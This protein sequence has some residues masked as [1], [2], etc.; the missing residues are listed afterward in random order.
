MDEELL[1]IV[2]E[3][4]RYDYPIVPKREYLTTQKIPLIRQVYAR[5]AKELY[6]QS[7]KEV[8]IIGYLKPIGKKIT[9]NERKIL[10][11]LG[12]D[13]ESISKYALFAETSQI[14]SDVFV[15]AEPYKVENYFL[16]FECDLKRL[17]ENQFYLL[18]YKPTYLKAEGLEL[19]KPS[20]TYSG[21]IKELS[22]YS[23]F[24]PLS[25]KHIFRSL[26]FPYIGCSFCRNI[27]DGFGVAQ[28]SEDKVEALDILKEFHKSLSSEKLGVPFSDFGIVNLVGESDIKK[29]SDYR[30]RLKGRARSISW[31]NPCSE[32]ESGLIKLSEL[33]YHSSE[34]VFYKGG[35][36]ELR[37]NLDLRYSLLLY[38]I[39]QKNSV[40]EALWK[41][42]IESATRVLGEYARTPSEKRVAYGIAVEPEKIPLLVGRTLSLSGAIGLDQ[43]DSMRMLNEI[44]EQNLEE[45]S[46]N[47]SKEAKIR[48]ETSEL[49]DPN[50]IAKI[51][52]SKDT[53]RDGIVSA[54]KSATG[55]GEIKAGKFFSQMA[56]EGHLLKKGGGYMLVDY[57]DFNLE[58]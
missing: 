37:D 51:V 34:P 29:V 56:N 7:K 24:S 53:T 36:R 27:S 8:S 55:W 54:I 22:N 49:I 47:I 6:N 43:D 42:G 52:I 2:G 20:L 41:K 17:G 1:S 40:N 44:V 33:K 9:L 32:K 18:K 13:S 11:S 46:L 35:F 5:A 21:L 23:S 38:S 19:D 16:P 30:I 50:I 31:L 4:L 48:K 25:G 57:S 26:T 12:L 3:K 14:Q 45:I 28:M 15:F 10:E 58:G 39:R